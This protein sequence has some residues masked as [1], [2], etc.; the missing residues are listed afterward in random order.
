MTH[1]I[2]KSSEFL[3]FELLDV[4]LR[5]EGFSCS[6][7]VFN[8]GLGK[9]NCIFFKS[10]NSNFPAVIFL[11]FLFIKTRDPEL[12]PDPQ[13]EQMLDPDPQLEQILDP[14]PLLEQM[15]DPDPH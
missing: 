14:D 1:R 12:D 7:C 5:A 11:K 8:R 4:L 2:E 15:L 13:F 9:V 3:C 6:L 10:K